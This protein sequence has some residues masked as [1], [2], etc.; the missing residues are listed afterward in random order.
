MSKF[1][2]LSKEQNKE[3]SIIISLWDQNL[4]ARHSHYHLMIK[5]VKPKKEVG[6]NLSSSPSLSFD[7]VSKCRPHWDMAR[8][9]TSSSQWGRGGEGGTGRK[10]RRQ[11]GFPFYIGCYKSLLISCFKS[12][13]RGFVN[14]W[15]GLMM[16]KVE[17]YRAVFSNFRKRAHFDQVRVYFYKLNLEKIGML[18]W[19]FANVFYK[20]KEQALYKNWS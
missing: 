15:C 9:H 6:G 16:A 1:V 14:I 18:S 7:G 10:G 4:L 5:K 3:E 19:K 17:W 2:K 11:C 12:F 20:K 8:I 13:N